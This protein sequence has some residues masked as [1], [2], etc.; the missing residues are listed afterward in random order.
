MFTILH[1]RDCHNSDILCLPE[2]IN[3]K[4]WMINAEAEEEGA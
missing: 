1:F 2:A 4:K 3:N